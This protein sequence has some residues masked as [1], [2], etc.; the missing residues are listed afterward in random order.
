MKPSPSLA[1]R[2]A[3]TALLGSAMVLPAAAHAQ[4]PGLPGDEERA[5]RGENINAF[6]D[7]SLN[8]EGV[9]A[10][11]NDDPIS[12][13]DVRQRAMLMFM[14]TGIQR[15]TPDLAAQLQSQALNDL[16]EERLKMQQAEERELDIPQAE[17]NA[18]FV[19][20]AQVNNVTVGEICDSLASYGIDPGTLEDRFRAQIAWQILVRGIYR[21]RVRVS[22]HQIEQVLERMAMNASTSQY[23]IQEILLEAPPGVSEADI[24]A[25]VQD[26]YRQLDAGADFRAIA[27]Q[28]SAAPSAI[29]Y[30][31]IGWV[32]A[33]EL[34]P[35]IE[36]VVMTMQ[37]GQVSNPV[38]TSDGIYLIKLVNRAEGRNP[39]RV[40][41]MQAM[42]SLPAGAS[43][44][45][46]AEIERDLSRT[47]RNVRGC[48]EFNEF[49][50]GAVTVNNLGFV[51]PSDLA[52]PFRDA[53]DAMS[54]GQVSAPV[55]YQNNVVVLG[56][57]ERSL[58]AGDEL[59]THDQ[60][61]NSL[62]EQQL[63]RSA[64]SWLRN[65]RQDA[66]IDIR[67]GQ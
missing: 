27:R 59:P 3:L 7:Y 39:E 2:L 23:E 17:I 21:S 25:G 36:D 67:I 20:I 24:E 33:G 5:C 10:L 40:S 49:A 42:V 22:N 30:G 19:N 61:E 46:F 65:L 64:R 6:A 31:Q 55:R 32:R 45:D 9:A 14:E 38:Y 18:E 48:N 43:E 35:E 41:L 63:S 12:K 29:N 60:I 58:T 28:Y 34:A 56:L 47:A 50:S 1:R 66:T 51:A 16:I 44:D 54:P 62:V 11:V 37:P 53:V 15:L 4:V 52:G 26:L 13:Y 8:D 57:C